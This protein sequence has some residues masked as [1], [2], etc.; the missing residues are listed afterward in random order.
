MMQENDNQLEDQ[1]SKVQSA[2]LKS[3][4]EAE[5]VKKV[6]AMEESQL[7]DELEMD[8][9]DEMRMESELSELDDNIQKETNYIQAS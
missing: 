6:I 1:K 8:G 2:Q 4:Q 9:M 3:Q 7:K 5:E